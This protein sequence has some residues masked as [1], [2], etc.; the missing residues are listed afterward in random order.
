[1]QKKQHTVCPLLRHIAQQNEFLGTTE[2]QPT[3]GHVN[4]WPHMGPKIHVTHG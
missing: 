3:G 1:M 2:I 4:F